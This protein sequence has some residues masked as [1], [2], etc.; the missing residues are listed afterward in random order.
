MSYLPKMTLIDS[1]KIHGN[2]FTLSKDQKYFASGVTV[3]A[4]LLDFEAKHPRFLIDRSKLK[5]AAVLSGVDFDRTA[6]NY[7]IVED[8]S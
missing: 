4:A 2:E 5:Q 3:N 7:V 8:I 6:G 1:V